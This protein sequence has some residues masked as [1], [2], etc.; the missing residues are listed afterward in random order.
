M[1]NLSGSFLSLWS[2][3]FVAFLIEAIYAPVFVYIVFLFGI[4]GFRSQISLELVEIAKGHPSEADEGGLSE[5]G[6]QGESDGNGGVLVETFFSSHA[7]PLEVSRVACDF[8]T[9][10]PQNVLLVRIPGSLHF[11]VACKTWRPG[12]TICC[13]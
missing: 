9:S 12:A 8:F 6:H 10:F 13:G 2:G 3:A 1:F 5:S 7:F 4:F 11:L